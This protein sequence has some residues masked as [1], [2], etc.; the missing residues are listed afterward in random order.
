MNESSFDELTC[1]Y[2]DG[3]YDKTLMFKSTIDNINFTPGS[4]NAEPTAKWKLKESDKEYKVLHYNEGRMDHIGRFNIPIE[5]VKGVP[6]HPYP[7]TVTE[8]GVWIVDIS[9]PL[10]EFGWDKPLAEEL[11]SFFK[12]EGVTRIADFG[13][14]DAAFVK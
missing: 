6:G 10:Y 13:C 9:Y 4:H 3:Q 2:S 8:R 11:D 7:F 5:V 14:G 12:E 1:G